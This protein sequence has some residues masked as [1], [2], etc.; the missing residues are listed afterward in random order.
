MNLKH[1]KISFL[2]YDGLDSGKSKV[3]ARILSWFNDSWPEPGSVILDA[4]DDY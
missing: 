2:Y 3:T 1:S 4:P